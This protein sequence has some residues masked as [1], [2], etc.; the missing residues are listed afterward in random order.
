MKVAS[1]KYTLPFTV[2]RVLTHQRSV[3]HLSREHQKFRLADG[4]LAIAQIEGEIGDSRHVLLRVGGRHIAIRGDTLVSGV[5]ANDLPFVLAMLA[6]EPGPIWLRADGG[7]LQSGHKSTDLPA[8]TVS[9][10]R[11]VGHEGLF[12]GILCEGTS[13]GRLYWLPQAVAAACTLTLVEARRIFESTKLKRLQVAMLPNGAISVVDHPRAAAELS[14]LKLG[15]S[16][17]VDRVEQMP[18]SRPFWDVAH[19]DRGWATIVVQSKQ[20]STI[21][22]AAVPQAYADRDTFPA[23]V[24]VRQDSDEGSRILLTVAGERLVASGVPAWLLGYETPPWSSGNTHY[25]DLP[26]LEGAS[27]HVEGLNG[28]AFQHIG[29]ETKREAYVRSGMA[30]L[31][32][33]AALAAA[34]DDSAENGKY[35]AATPSRVSLLRN[36]YAR[37]LRS[38]PLEHLARWGL[39]EASGMSPITVLWY[40]KLRELFHHG[41]LVEAREACERWLDIIAME[42]VRPEEEALASAFAVMIGVESRPQILVQKTSFLPRVIS[43]TRPVYLAKVPSADVMNE[44]SAQVTAVA[45]DLVENGFDIPLAAAIIF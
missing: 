9:P 1:R 38:L 26:A 5:S 40:S 35:A 25:L 34:P 21:F 27:A 16:I 6:S 17:F 39:R 44:A 15:A 41:R 3:I 8:F 20:T 24:A 10:M 43:A 14:K 19:V 33:G 45:L 42:G 29:L 18:L 12:L 11:I 22:A 36:L 30:S 13:D 4:E 23:E 31:I 2:T 37:A 28:G 32:L 7:R